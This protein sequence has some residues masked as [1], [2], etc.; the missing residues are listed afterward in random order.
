MAGNKTTERQLRIWERK[1]GFDGEVVV[2][3]AVTGLGDVFVHV[4]FAVERRRPSLESD[5]ATTR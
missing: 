3:P 4:S 5:L 2:G 1:P